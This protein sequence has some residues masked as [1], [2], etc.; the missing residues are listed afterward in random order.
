[1]NNII[2]INKEDYI[3]IENIPNGNC[4][5]YSLAFFDVGNDKRK[6]EKRAKEIRQDLRFKPMQGMVKR[7]ME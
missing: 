6:I 1:M 3:P 7:V 5:F 2:R 4:L